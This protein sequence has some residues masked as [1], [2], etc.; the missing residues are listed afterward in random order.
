MQYSVFSVRN[1]DRVL[2]NILSEVEM[3]YR[4][5]FKK[6]DSILIFS[7]CQGCQKKIVRYGSAVHD[8]EDVIYFK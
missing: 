1:S 7:L 3:K 2:K 6:T 4:K 5:R 8:I